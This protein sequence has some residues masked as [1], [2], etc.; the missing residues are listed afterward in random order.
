VRR[1]RFS[2]LDYYDRHVV[3][4]HAVT[5]ENASQRKAART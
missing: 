5:L 3:L 1:L 2:K 4:D